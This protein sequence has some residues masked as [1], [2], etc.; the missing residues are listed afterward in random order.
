VVAVTQRVVD[1]PQRNERRDVL[2]QAW[3][4]FLEICGLEMIVIPNR[5]ADAATYAERRGVTAAI[6]TGGNNIS[7][8]IGTLSG[9]AP[10]LPAC[11]I[12]LA[13]ERDVVET[14]LLRASVERGWPVIGV[15]RG[16][17]VLNVFHGGAL[18]PVTGHA[19]KRHALVAL[20]GNAF[21]SEVNSF[22]DFGVPRDHRGRELEVLATA[23]GWSEAIE[24]PRLRHLGIMWHPERNRPFSAN[25]VAL[26][27]DYLRRRPS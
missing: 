18:A 9:S 16:L 25:D 1:M 5:V 22:H 8:S 14:T 15:C 12:D 7:S 13:P 17:Q 11:E 23:D 26:F 21:D 19:G 3:A 2:D 4:P 24:H 27:R 10:R 6:L 20:G